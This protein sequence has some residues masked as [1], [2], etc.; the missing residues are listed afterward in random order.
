MNYIEIYKE[1][2]EESISGRYITLEHIEP[3]LAKYTPEVIGKSVLEKP[4]YKLQFG[5][6]RIK[7]LN[8]KNS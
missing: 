4:I 2:K 1:Y 6:G 7:I 5:T 8:V 3:L